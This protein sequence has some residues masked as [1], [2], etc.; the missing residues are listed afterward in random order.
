MTSLD[1]VMTYITERYRFNDETYP[2][3][4][5]L[6]MEEKRRFAINHS[7]LHMNKSIGKLAAEVESLDHGGGMD[8]EALRVATVKM[9]VNT[10]VLAE[11]LGMDDEQLAGAVPGV[12]KSK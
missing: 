4:S 11:R 12:M 2:G 10:L 1:K 9:F 6:T 7:I 3:F 5:K 8:E